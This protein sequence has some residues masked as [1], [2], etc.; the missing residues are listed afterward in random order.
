MLAD[1]AAVDLDTIDDA[2][3]TDSVLPYTSPSTSSFSGELYDVFRIPLVDIRHVIALFP[4][5]RKS[6]RD[7]ALSARLFSLKVDVKDA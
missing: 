5:K 2:G 6:P 4:G 1:D 7:A 3:R